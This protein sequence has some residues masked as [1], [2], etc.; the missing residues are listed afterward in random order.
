MD[1]AVNF[2]VSSIAKFFPQCERNLKQL[3][4]PSV[5]LLFCLCHG[6]ALV[7]AF[8]SAEKFMTYSA[9]CPNILLN[10]TCI[11]DQ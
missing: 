10:K 4:P 11:I 8:Y 7:Q 6:S 3:S 5:L 1:F 2:L 9:I